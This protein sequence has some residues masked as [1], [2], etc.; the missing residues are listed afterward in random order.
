M[1]QAEPSWAAESYAISCIL[2]FVGIIG[3]IALWRWGRN[4]GGDDS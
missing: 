4:S 3:L 2:F 1:I